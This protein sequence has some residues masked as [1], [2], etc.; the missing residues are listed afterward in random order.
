MTVL[1]RIQLALLTGAAALLSLSGF[2]GLRILGNGLGRL[3]WLALPSRRR[4]ATHN[5][6]VHLHL[7]GEDAE[8][9][10]KE[11]FRHNARSFLEILLT[12]R[13]GMN[14]PRL[15][16]ADPETFEK[17][18][19][20]KRPIV[21]VTAHLGAWE[22]LAAMLGE[23]YEAPRPRVVVVR[24]YKNPVVQTFISS[25]R[26]ARGATMA[27]HRTVA[28]TVLRALRKNGIVAFLVD[29]NALRSEALFMPFL[30]EEAA[31]NMGPALLSL[32]AEAL[33]MPVYLLREGNNY[34]AHFRPPLD[35]ATLEGDRESKVAAITRFYTDEVEKA[36]AKAPEQW[37][38]M[39]NRWKQHSRPTA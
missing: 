14:S 28:A 13:F 2:T 33:V 23:L 16:I 38:W 17:L 29:H 27:G 9:M 24:R 34:V 37:F 7:S 20:C 5:I 32:R 31:I 22:L 6:A 12:R 1:Q 10:A 11:S 25:R 30:G 36:I 26:E 15:R 35:T 39:H 21:A 8:K 18:L 4:L 19:Q 3:M